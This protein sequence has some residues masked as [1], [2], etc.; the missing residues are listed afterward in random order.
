MDE[1][2]VRIETLLHA[3][4]G[5]VWKAWTD[6]DTVLKWF[7]SDPEGSGLKA[8]IDLRV[9]G[10]YEISFQNADQTQFTCLG[11]YSEVEEFHKLAFNWMWENEPGVISQVTVLLTP[12]GKATRMH[13]EHRDLGTASAH[14][15]AP[16][17]QRT[18]EK[19][20]RML[21]TPV[22]GNT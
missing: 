2:K 18:F 21:L 10:Q 15:Y 13:F 6:R 9:G 19:L 5:E 14:D 3:P 16:G 7:G 1:N 20:R 11:E 12:D 22:A 17:W 4:V 8:R